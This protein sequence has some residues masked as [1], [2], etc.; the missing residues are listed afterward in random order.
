VN[1]RP[2]ARNAVLGLAATRPSPCIILVGGGYAIYR[3]R[4]PDVTHRSAPPTHHHRKEA[5][6]R[7]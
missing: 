5:P 6:A 2:A 1:T 3:S 7:S 4:H